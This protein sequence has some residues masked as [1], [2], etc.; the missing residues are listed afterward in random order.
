MRAKFA[1][2]DAAST[3]WQRNLEISYAKIG[4]LLAAQGRA[5]EMSDHYREALDFVEKLAAQH[6]ENTKWAAL[7]QSLKTQTDK[8]ER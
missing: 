5:R 6:P 4:D 2:R 8:E 3:T 1:T 7:A